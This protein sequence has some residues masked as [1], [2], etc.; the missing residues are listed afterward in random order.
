MKSIGGYFELEFRDGEHFHKNAIKLSTA[1]QCFEYILRVRKYKKIYI[2]YYTCDVLLE[3]IKK[4]KISYE[5]YHIDN[6]FNPILKKNLRS[7][8]AFLYTNYFGLK[9]DTVYSLSKRFKNLIIDNAQ[10]F[11]ADPIKGVDTFYSARKFFGVPDGAYLYIGKLLEKEFPIYD[12]NYNMKHLLGRL[13]SSAEE[14]YKYF[15]K[16]EQRISNTGIHKM[17]VISERILCSLD[18]QHII[19]KRRFNY[20][21]LFRMLEKYNKF[22]FNI[23]Y[24]DAVPMAFPLLTNSNQLRSVLI[25]NKIYIPQYWHNVSIW[26][27]N[28]PTVESKFANLLCALPIDQRYGKDEMNYIIDNLLKNKDL[29]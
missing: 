18:Y 5:F 17:S 6:N 12:S 25:A 8:E 26:L 13:N 4:L 28:T 10:A 14:Y 22:H 29:L 23:S 21:Y 1:R 9:Q 19:Q 27:E 11:F 3:P 24:T 15:Q 2:P 7:E 20:V 16:S